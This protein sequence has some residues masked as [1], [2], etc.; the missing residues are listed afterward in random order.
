MITPQTDKKYTMVHA[1][2]GSGGCSSGFDEEGFET[3]AAFQLVGK[4]K[5]WVRQKRER[6]PVHAEVRA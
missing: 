5:I 4:G 1:F 6:A 3:L 2:S